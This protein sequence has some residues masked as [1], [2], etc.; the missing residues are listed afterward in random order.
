MVYTSLEDFF[1]ILW[2]GNLDDTRMELLTFVNGV[3]LDPL[4]F[5]G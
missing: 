4:Q 2:S 3:Q 5:Q 1:M